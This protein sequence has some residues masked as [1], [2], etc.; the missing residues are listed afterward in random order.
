MNH[1]GGYSGIPGSSEQ[2]EA[3]L[4]AETVAG[5]GKVNRRAAIHMGSFVGVQARVDWEG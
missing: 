2:T 4:V 3:I 1:K 5:Q